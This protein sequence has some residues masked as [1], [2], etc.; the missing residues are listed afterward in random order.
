MWFRC[1]LS[2]P[3]RGLISSMVIWL[4]GLALLMLELRE[5]A[6]TQALPYS[7]FAFFFPAPQLTGRRSLKPRNI[8][9]AGRGTGELSLS[10]VGGSWV[11]VRVCNS[12][13]ISVKSFP[14]W[15]LA[16][17]SAEA[18]YPGA[19]ASCRACSE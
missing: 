11:L 16:T 5:E 10:Q 17:P 1:R 19:R 7:T 2:Y 15:G 13:G 3:S 8:R 14:G 4:P 18:P 12:H 9:G 6:W